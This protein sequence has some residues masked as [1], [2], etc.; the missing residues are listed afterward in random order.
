MM[1][2]PRGVPLAG[3]VLALSLAVSGSPAPV[4]AQQAPP[5]PLE[6]R[7]IEFPAFERFSLANGIEVV[8]LDYGTQPVASIRLYQRGG[9]SLV[10]ASRAGVGE[11][12]ATLLTR[13]TAAR[14]AREI[15]ETIE[16]V[17]GSLAAGSGQDF[18]NVS[19]TVLTDHLEVAFRLLAD[20]ARHASFPEDEV[21]LARRQ[22]LS[23][24][25]AQQGQPQALASRFFR[26][27]V[28]GEEHPYGAS[29]TPET[30]AAITRD[31]LVRFRDQALQPEGALLLVAGP[32]D[33]ARVESLAERYLGDWTGR[34]AAA[35]HLVPPARP[36]G[37]RIHL[38]HR[39]GS[40]QS[41]ILAGQPGVEGRDPD[42][43][44]VEV[45]NRVLGGGADSR[46][47]RILRE[48]RGWTYGAFSGVTRPVGTGL[49]QVSTEVRAPVTDSA[50]VEILHQMDRMGTEPVPP[51]E[52]DA[53]RNY[54]AGSFPLQL[55]TAGQVAGRLATTLLLGRDVDEVTR[56][57]ERIRA[58]G[59]DDAADV[60]QRLMR[61]D[62]TVVVVVGDATRILEGLESIAPVTLLDI[63][64]EE[65][66]RAEVLAPADGGSPWDASRLE[67][68]VRRYELRFDGN[69]VGSATYRLERED[70]T[71]V[72][73]TTVSQAMGG[74]QETILRFDATHFTPRSL[75]QTQSAPGLE[76]EV[77]LEVIDGRIVGRANLPPQLGG[78]RE[79][80]HPAEG[81]LLPGMD[82]FA[83]AASI[84]TE[85]VR[86]RIAYLDVVQD[87]P[88]T[89]EARVVG[90]EVVEVPA[91][92]FDTWRVE[93]GTGQGTLTVFLRVEG[94]HIL[95]KQLF[96]GQPVTLEL[97][98]ISPL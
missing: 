79:V 13:G 65:L 72:A 14:S 37:T 85:D 94:P 29:P 64:G 10:P 87:Q 89:L 52:M 11:L 95:V 92:S 54:L 88:I 18:L 28:Y 38:V 22:L 83:M 68:G 80:D 44:A 67:E 7:P 33:R 73:T 86:L 55:E 20:V 9:S 41:V 39:P 49:F 2:R 61:P 17:G 21:E 50:V 25:Q 42:F 53:A 4:E 91:G 66:D 59:P 76:L 8:V 31:D 93:V 6:P 35:P 98:G 32:V 58:V 27:L 36:E 48:E 43:A 24:L 46:L 84:L 63:Q 34:P 82:E 15:S 23:G 62:Q 57:P 60:G 26:R 3:V 5:P 96:P 16:G 70:D 69:P 12:A 56:F 97:A 19:A 74:G 77:E 78:S 51:E 40:V 47:F 45:A 81:L 1:P 75:R 30:V 71:W 90:R